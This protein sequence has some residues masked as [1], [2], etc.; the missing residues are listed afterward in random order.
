MDCVRTSP[1]IKSHLLSYITINSWDNRIII[2]NL[3]EPVGLS[4]RTYDLVNSSKDS[5]TQRCSKLRITGSREMAKWLR[6]LAS[7]DSEF[8]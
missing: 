8:I 4:Y 6:A 3:I 7:R 1:R 5:Y 2:I